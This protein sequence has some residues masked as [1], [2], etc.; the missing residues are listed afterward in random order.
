MSFSAPERRKEAAPSTCLGAVLLQIA[1]RVYR[2]R[3][4]LSKEGKVFTRQMWTKC[5]FSSKRTNAFVASLDP[6]LPFHSLRFG[7]QRRKRWPPDV[8]DDREERNPALGL[9]EEDPASCALPL[10]AGGRICREDLGRRGLAGFA[11]EDEAVENGVRAH[12]DRA[13]HPRSGFAGG[14]EAGDRLLA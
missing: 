9:R 3:R 5:Q 8:S 11:A 12:A 2:S 1:P 4:K 14:V 10:N 7:I 6:N 13:V